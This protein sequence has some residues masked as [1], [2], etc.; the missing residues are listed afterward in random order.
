MFHVNNQ[1]HPKQIKPFLFQ[2]NLEYMVK[3]IKIGIND[4]IDLHV[5]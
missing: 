4:E 3:R 2:K 1:N 5:E